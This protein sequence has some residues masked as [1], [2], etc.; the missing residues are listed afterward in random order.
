M[1][2]P[3]APALTLPF[4]PLTSLLTLSL[5]LNLVSAQTY[6]L[7]HR[8]LPTTT[9]TSSSL[10]QLKSY[11]SISLSNSTVTVPGAQTELIATF[12]KLPNAEEISLDALRAESEAIGDEK[13]ER[14]GQGG[15]YQV[16]LEDPEAHGGEEGWALAV[17]KAVSEREGDF[18][19]ST[20]CLSPDLL[21]L[22]MRPKS[23]HSHSETCPCSCLTPT[24]N[25]ALLLNILCITHKPQK[26]TTH[27]TDIK[28]YLPHSPLTLTIHHSASLPPSIDLSANGIPR[29]G[30]CP[31][32]STGSAEASMRGL[33]VRV[34]RAARA[35]R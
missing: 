21:E 7:H 29:D 1:R 14:R 32:S 34:Q 18:K 2:S 16:A 30:A 23:T 26:P 22:H 17:T 4:T 27:P 24:T 8:L 31:D 6:I 19:V 28:C 35:Y 10:P 5:L 20:G 11:G 33:Q 9:G 25:F 15:W 13:G 3:L 12:R